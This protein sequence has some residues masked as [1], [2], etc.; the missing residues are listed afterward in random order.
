[1]AATPPDNDLSPLTIIITGAVIGAL[2]GLLKVLRDKAAITARFAASGVLTGLFTGMLTI[3]SLYG[4][5]KERDS[6]YMLLA[7]AGLAGY[8]G[9][10][11][12]DAALA[13][14]VK[15]IGTKGD[16]VAGNLSGGVE[17]RKKYEDS[18]SDEVSR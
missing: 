11:I 18:P 6:I 5:A 3:L 15:F 12:L 16:Q 17:R 14:L 1:M 10:M 4:L 7:V 13:V 9:A 2:G 8:G